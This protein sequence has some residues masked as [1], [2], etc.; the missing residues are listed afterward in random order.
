[1]VAAEPA[2][3]FSVV[4]LIPRVDAD[5]T[6]VRPVAERVVSV[7]SNINVLLLELKVSD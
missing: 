1:M 6:V 2:P 3:R 5:V 4:A 7:L